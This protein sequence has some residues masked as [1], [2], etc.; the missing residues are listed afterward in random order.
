MTSMQALPLS[1]KPTLFLKN[2]SGKFD[3]ALSAKTSSNHPVEHIIIQL[4]LPNEVC[5][6]KINVNAGNASFDSLSKVCFWNHAC[7]II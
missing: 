2:Q 7:F 3:L 4:K 1:I 5:N 6:T